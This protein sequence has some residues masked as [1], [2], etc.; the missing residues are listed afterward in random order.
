MFILY[1]FDEL[2]NGNAQ[3]EKPF[4]SVLLTMM[5]YRN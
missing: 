1:L 3:K 4:T 2:L 5:Q